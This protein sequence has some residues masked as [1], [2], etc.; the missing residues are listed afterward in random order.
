MAAAG[1]HFVPVTVGLKTATEVQVTSGLK[2]GEQIV[3]FLPV[4]SSS[5]PG[6]STSGA[7]R[8]FGPGAFGGGAGGLAFHH[9]AAGGGA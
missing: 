8:L 9:G 1:L 6:A 3:L 2:P 7:G 5:A 4:L